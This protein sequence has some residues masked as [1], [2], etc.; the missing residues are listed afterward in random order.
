[1]DWYLLAPG[2]SMSRELA[3]SVRGKSV[4]VV[5]AAFKLAPWADFLAANDRSWWMAHKDANEFEGRKFSAS[6]IRG[7]EKIPRSGGIGTST[8]SGVLA[9]EVAK[10]MGATKIALLG[11]DM[12]GSHYFGPYTCGLSNTTQDRRNVHLRQYERWARE[13]PSVDVVNCT[14]GSNLRCFR[15]GSLDQCF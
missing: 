4:G 13:N 7:V 3:D 14:E 11:F 1:M 9:L 2:P 6:D 8:N 15:M 12:H 5:T 10:Q